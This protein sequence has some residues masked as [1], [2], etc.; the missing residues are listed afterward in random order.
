VLDYPEPTAVL[1]KIG[2]RSLDFELRCYLGSRA[3]F[4]SF[5]NNLHMELND[6]LRRAGVEFFISE[7]PSM[8]SVNT[9]PPNRQAA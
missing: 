2:P 1:V 6:A 5:Q 7:M 9:A 8:T 4:S 3:S